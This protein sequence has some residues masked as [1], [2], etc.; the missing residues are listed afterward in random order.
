MVAKVL[1]FF[2]VSRGESLDRIYLFKLLGFGVFLHKIHANDPAHIYHNHPWNGFSIIFGRYLEEFFDEAGL[3]WQRT[4]FNFVNAKRHHRVEIAEPV[5][6]L[7]FHGR[8]SN[9]WEIIDRRGRRVPAPWEGAEGQ[10]S[11]TKAAA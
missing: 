9:Q 1:G 7:F 5:W 11:Y 10:K 2:K 4:G 3:F 6:T 8:K